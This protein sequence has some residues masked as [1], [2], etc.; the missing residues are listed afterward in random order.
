MQAT[1]LLGDSALLKYTSIQD[2]LSFSLPPS[3]AARRLRGDPQTKKLRSDH[4]T[5]I[6]KDLLNFQL[7]FFIF[8]YCAITNG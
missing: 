3:P 8:I 5:L 1:H 4:F 2:D 7:S 6:Q